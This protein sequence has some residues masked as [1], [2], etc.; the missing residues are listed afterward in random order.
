VK[1]R[2]YVWLLAA[3]LVAWLLVP[4]S[5]AHANAAA[6][7][8][9]GASCA[10]LAA[11][12]RSATNGA[13]WGQTLLPGH[14]APGGWFGVDVCANATNLVGP[15]GANVSCDRL[16]FD[17]GRTGCAPGRATFDGF[18]LS[19]QCVELVARF[20]AWAFGDAPAD[21]HG[22][23]PDLWLPGNHPADM[24]ALANGG[25]AAPVPGD[26]LVWGHT[27][28]RGAPWPSGPGDSHDGHVAV[29]AAVGPGIL[30][31]VEQN[32]LNGTRNV[33]RETI[34]LTM[35]DG[36]W[37]AGSYAGPR[38]LYGWLH[39]VRNTGRWTG[40][41]AV[42]GAS[43]AAATP[44][45][46]AA[47]SWTATPTPA[48]APAPIAL[49]ALNAGV[50]VTPA[51][52]LTALDWAGGRLAAPERGAVLAA[53]D[54]RPHVSN[55]DLG[56]PA[57]APLAQGQAP[58]VLSSAAGDDVYALGRDGRLYAAHLAPHATQ[59]GWSSLGAPA[60]VVFAGGVAAAAIPGAMAI[61][62][63][64]TDGT[65]WW[66]AGP[67]GSLGDW[68]SIG[69]PAGM[70]LV[71]PPVLAGQPG[72]GL[73]LAVALGRDGRLYT[74]AWSVAGDGTGDLAGA[75]GAWSTIALPAAAGALTGPLMAVSEASGAQDQIGA[76]TDGALDLVVRSVAGGIW[77]VHRGPQSTTQTTW[78]ATRLAADGAA[79]HL[80]GAV[81][82]PAAAGDSSHW[83]HV[84]TALQGTISQ[85]EVELPATSAPPAATWTAFDAAASLHLGQAQP[86]A[87]VVGTRASVLVSATGGTLALLGL[88]TA[89]TLL[90][91]AP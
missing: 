3:L 44:T 27:S 50:L 40:A 72:S 7:L 30:T 31:F 54:A 86:T 29:V 4:A 83:V 60:G 67:P 33:A 90:S 85:A 22:D 76:W 9:A 12:D 11:A 14:G 56:A 42:G 13:I 41:A 68:A 62:A 18:G 32:A 61:A 2:R 10:A 53:S 16:P 75:W 21:W 70:R 73:P 28:A 69:Q 63:V 5:S 52:T 65:L 89:L 78:S 84:Y 87:L 49:P 20:A 58:V 47:P 38:V 91:G 25:S 34:A 82:P 19:F 24:T 59:A 43:P 74:V 15:G 48:A 71:G 46:T 39:S 1:H 88:P 66:R 55:V 36:R 35:R 80:L 81:A 26:I 64:A 79:D 45:A 8:P 77:L 6:G 17:F 51:G 37:I 23:A 57:S